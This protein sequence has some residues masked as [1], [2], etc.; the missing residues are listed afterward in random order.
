MSTDR[1]VIPGIVQGGIVLPQSKVPLPEGSA[2][3]IVVAAAEMSPELRAE[4]LAW[5]AAGDEA[6][7]LIDDW[8]SEQS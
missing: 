5:E 2:V 4:M 6:W 1:L 7:G 8:E 3:D